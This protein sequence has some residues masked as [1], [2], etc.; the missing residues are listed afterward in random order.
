MCD[1]AR[2]ALGVLLCG[3]LVLAGCFGRADDAGPPT[4]PVPAHDAGVSVTFRN[5]DGSAEYVGDVACA[6]CHETEYAGFQGHGMAR[7]FARFDPD[8]HRTERPSV[9]VVDSTTG[10]AYTVR[11]EAD[12]WYQEE[13]LRVGDG[14][15]IHRLK[16]RMDFVVGSGNAAYTFL[17]AE[18]DR[19]FELPL[20]WYTQRKTWDMSP[21]YR[22]RN[23]RFDRLITDRC[24]ACHNAYPTPVPF[25]DGKY[26]TLP[27]GI[28]CERCH[29]PGSLHVGERLSDPDFDRDVDETIVNPAHLPFERRLDVCRQCHF[30]APVMV[31]REGHT[32]FDFLP[33]Q[34]LSDHLAAFAPPGT[35][36]AETV[37]VISHADRMRRSACYLGSLEAPKPLECVTCHNPHEGFRDQGPSYFNRT[38]LTCH[39]ADALP[40]AVHTPAANCIACHMPRVAVEDAPHATFT[41]HWIRVV[42]RAASPASSDEPLVPYFARDVK[43]RKGQAYLGMALVMQGRQANDLLR[44]AQ[45]AATLEVALRADTAFGEAY[46]LL[47]L[48]HRLL[49]NV[50]RAIPALERAVRLAPDVPQRLGALALAYEAAHRP[51]GIIDRLYRQAL[52]IQPALASVRVD[53]GWFLLGQGRAA[54]AAAAFRNARAERPGLAEAALGL[55]L[56][57]TAQDSLGGAASVFRTALHLDPR[58]AGVLNNLLIVDREAVRPAILFYDALLDEERIGEAIHL[59]PAPA[60]VPPRVRLAGVPPGT[61]LKVYTRAGILAQTLAGAED[62]DLRDAAGRALPDGLYLLHVPAAGRAPRVLRFAVIRR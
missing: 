28:G 19:L 8:R 52:R 56:A 47:G 13:L 55:G 3:L 21:G 6:T 24:M 53:A 57:L 12:G 20:T 54:E 33:S 46:F 11:E 48:A 44:L 9:P 2:I 51:P 38:C 29:G 32:A 60:A 4:F 1:E 49:G 40:A 22:A 50:D 59:M 18:N 45:G 43:N 34:A 41:D 31:L 23:A 25:A 36:G 39:A 30:S 37:G 10:Y 58:Y 35:G 15:V 16:K 7:A 61:T 17:T 5:V 42:G 14:R 62:W 26:T 27:E